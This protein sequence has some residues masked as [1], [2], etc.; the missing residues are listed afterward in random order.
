ML[1]ERVDPNLRLQE[2]RGPL[3]GYL[4]GEGLPRLPERRRAQAEA[5]RRRDRPSRSR[6]APG[7]RAGGAQER[8]PRTAQH[9]N[10]RPVAHLLR[11]DPA[12]AQRGRDRR[13]P[14]TPK[15]HH[16]EAAMSA[17]KFVKSKVSIPA[18]K[19]GMRP[20]HPGE[21]LREDYL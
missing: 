20:I 10:Q 12:R 7:Q 16:E 1:T 15:S 6:F 8:P 3:G 5:A 18:G 14:L 17:T 9:P 4:R 11:L 19:N 2:D 21:V 13:L